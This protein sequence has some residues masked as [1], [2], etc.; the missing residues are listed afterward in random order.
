[1][2]Q[3]NSHFS[4]LNNSIFEKA[5]LEVESL[6]QLDSEDVCKMLT[7]C[8]EEQPDFRLVNDPEMINTIN[9]SQDMW[10]AGFNSQFETHTQDDVKAYLGT[11]V[12]PD[13]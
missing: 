2:E 11:V 1:M 12:D 10:T 7:L 4:W 8:V 3:L 5:E 6:L 9:S 13:V